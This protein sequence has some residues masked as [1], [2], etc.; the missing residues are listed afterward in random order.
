MTICASCGHDVSGKKFCPACGTPVQ[1]QV[2]QAVSS[3]PRCHGEVKF[4][5]AFCMHCGFALSASATPAM[6]PCPAC[7]AQV[8]GAS[9]FCTNCGQD[10]RAPVAQ[11]ASVCCA[12]CGHLNP[13]GMRFCSS[14]GNQL[15]SDAIATTGY[16]LSGQYP[17]PTQNPQQSTPVYQQPYSQ[18]QYQQGQYQQPQYPEPYSQPQYQYGQNAYLPQPMMGQ[19]PMVLRCPTCMAM[20]PLG[21]TNCVSCRTSLVGVVPVPANMPMQGQQAGFLQGNGGKF[22]MGA[23]GGVAAVVGGEML[24]HGVERSVENRMEGDMRFGRHRHR[25]EGLLGELGELADDVGL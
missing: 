8:S 6:R 17:Q 10:L 22:A 13:A 24:L 11:S 23:L 19:A 20:A 12:N 4:G 7:H 14:C 18:P 9:A 16:T 21:S 15:A 25:D 5:A 3:C 2:T 1:P